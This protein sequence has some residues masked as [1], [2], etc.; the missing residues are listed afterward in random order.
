M[1]QEEER[2]PMMRI[3]YVDELESVRQNLIQMGETT[4]SLLAEAMRTVV[5]PNSGPSERASELARVANRSSASA[6]P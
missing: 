5:D 6:H 1:Q 3:H 2:E 4:I